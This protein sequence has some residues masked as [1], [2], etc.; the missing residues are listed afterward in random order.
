MIS[1][2]VCAIVKCLVIVFALLATPDLAPVPFLLFPVVDFGVQPL[3]HGWDGLGRVS[4]EHVDHF[5]GAPSVVDLGKHAAEDDIQG[6]P[7]GR[8][9]VVGLSSGVQCANVLGHAVKHANRSQAALN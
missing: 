6:G 3:H 2:S 9:L 4:M 7:G 5:V 8:R 1:K